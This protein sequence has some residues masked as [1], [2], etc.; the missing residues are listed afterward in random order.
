MGSPR[1]INKA[2]LVSGFSLHTLRRWNRRSDRAVVAACL[3]APLIPTEFLGLASPRYRLAPAEGTK[4]YQRVLRAGPRVP[5]ALEVQ[6]PQAI[7]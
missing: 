3:W 7:P 4:L 5:W 2:V 6:L 1:M